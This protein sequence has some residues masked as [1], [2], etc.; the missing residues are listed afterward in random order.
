M[1]KLKRTTL[2]KE[3]TPYGK[4]KAILDRAMEHI[5]GVDYKVS[6][7]W[8]FYRLLQESFYSS[9]EDYVNLIMLSARARKNWYNGWT[10]ETLADETR[11]MTVFHSQGDYHDPDIN[12]LADNEIDRAE[13]RLTYFKRQIKDYF[14][15]FSYTVDSNYLQ[16]IF[17]VVMFE[18]RAML[19]QFVK[20]TNGL[21]LC[22]FG[23]QPSIPYKWQIAKYIESQ[24]V[25]Y[26]KDCAVLYFGDLDDAGLKIFNSGKEDIT[27]WCGSKLTFIRCGLTQEQVDK[28]GVPENFEHPGSYQWEALS[29]PQAKEIIEE[30]IYRFHDPN[31]QE[32]AIAMGMEISEKVNSVVNDAMRR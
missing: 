20:Y 22:P 14:H 9:K 11:E 32:K 4:T 24:C 30:H 10:P 17:L 1:E 7:R 27:R 8:V 5:R 13:A 28:F 23:G 21:T 18:A 19:S 25:K 3:Y 6:A 26:E 2:E 15:S 31:L 16:H 29:D 12:L